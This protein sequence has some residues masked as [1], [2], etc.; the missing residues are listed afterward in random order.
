MFSPSAASIHPASMGSSKPPQ[1]NIMLTPKQ[2]SGLIQARKSADVNFPS[3]IITIF[4][5]TLILISTF[6][7]GTGWTLAVNKE[8]EGKPARGKYWAFALGMTV[9]TI[10]L[11]VSF[12]VAAEI[13]NKSGR[14]DVK[15]DNILQDT[16]E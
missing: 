16:V 6:I 10:L 5:S 14:V 8:F 2:F 11:A 13:L 4:F 3:Y 15:L 9:L 7:T 12:G 1:S